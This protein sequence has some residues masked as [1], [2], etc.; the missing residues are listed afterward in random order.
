MIFHLS[1]GGQIQVGATERQL[2]RVRT[3]I[4]SGHGVVQMDGKLMN[5]TH[6]VG[7]E[8]T[9]DEPDEG[10]QDSCNT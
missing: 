1:T 10:D 8:Y 3:L 9:Q 4:G 6:I 7:V 5:V 2:E